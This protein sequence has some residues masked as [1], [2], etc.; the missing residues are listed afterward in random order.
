MKVAIV[1]GASRGIGEAIARSLAAKGWALALA[2]R[3]AAEIERLAGELP[4]AIAL[5]TDITR[6]DEVQ[7]LIAAAMERWGRIDALVNNAGV[8]HVSP[9][10]EIDPD[11]FDRLMAVNVKGPF[12]CT[13]AVLPVMRAQSGG[14]ILNVVSVAAKRAFPEW[15]AYCASKFALDGMGKALAEELKGTGI[16]VS[17]IYPGATDSPLWDAIGPEIP[18][19]GMMRAETV[20]EAVAFM[21]EQPA[22]ARLSELVLDPAAGDV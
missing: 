11:V 14:D 1:T 9:F 19:G 15:S 12:L 6:P 13:Q 5:P 17:A 16:R 10:E 21:L 3:S 22:S 8:T 2:A 7:R 20:G 18:R 4:E